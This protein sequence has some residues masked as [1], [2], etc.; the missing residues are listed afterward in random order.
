VWN[1]SDGGRRPMLW[2]RRRTRSVARRRPS[3]PMRGVAAP[4]QTARG[5]RR[6]LRVRRVCGFDARVRD[7]EPSAGLPRPCRPGVAVGPPIAQTG[8]ARE[9]RYLTGCGWLRR[10][11]W[12]APAG[13]THRGPRV[14][15]G[16]YP[17]CDEHAG[18]LELLT[19]TDAARRHRSAGTA[20]R[21]ARRLSVDILPPSDRRADRPP[22]AAPYLVHPSIG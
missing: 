22:A 9:V 2:P 4:H 18:G 17:L 5:A 12:I 8:V 1:V 14:P 11:P 10:L 15:A 3:S 16:L 21:A 19:A 13:G 7:P 20:P 6:G